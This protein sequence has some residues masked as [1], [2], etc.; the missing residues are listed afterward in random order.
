MPD[1]LVSRST[2]VILAVIGALVALAAS[3]LRARGWGRP[4]HLAAL[5]RAGYG[6]M[7]AS[8]ALFIYAGFRS[9]Y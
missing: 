4:E 9:G 2:V 1:W 5:N 6:C 3:F 8:V 7:W